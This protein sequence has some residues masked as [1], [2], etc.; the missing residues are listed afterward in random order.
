MDLD[1]FARVVQAV[2]PERS[3]ALLET[4]HARLQD[5]QGQHDRI[6]RDRG[7]GFIC[8]L[9]GRDRNQV[10]ARASSL[11]ACVGAEPCDTAGASITLTASAGLVFADEYGA[12]HTYRRAEMALVM[13]KIAGRND[14]VDFDALEQANFDGLTG[15]FNRRHF[16]DRFAREIGLAQRSQGR[17]S[18]ALF[19]LDDFGCLNK[20]HGHPVGDAALTGFAAAARD[21]VGDRGWVARYGGEEFCAVARLPASELAQLAERVRERTAELLIPTAGGGVTTVTV[22]VGVAAWHGAG[23]SEVVQRAST[24]LKAAKSLGK[25]RVACEDQLVEGA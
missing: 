7:D 9:A 18:L 6:L 14:L 2:G 11:Q 8:L 10:L 25:N 1:Q 3:E 5:R 19:D 22:S 21:L 12:A 16:D 23:A 15:V 24:L 20:L 4:V 13:A 17:L